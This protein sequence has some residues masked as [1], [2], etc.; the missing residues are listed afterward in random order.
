MVVKYGRT[1]LYLMEK[2]TGDSE[3]AKD[4]VQDAFIIVLE[5][6]RN[7]PLDDPTKLSAYLYNTAKN[8]YIGETRKEVRR[9]TF[10]DTELLEM[11]ASSNG[12]QYQTLVLERSRA[13]IDRLFDDLRN[14]RD[15]MILIHYYIDEIEKDIIC[16]NLGLSHR[17]FDRVI[18]RARSRFRDIVQEQ[19]DQIPL[20]VSA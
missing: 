13:A 20:E 4:V 6:L 16:E 5:K 1:L 7:E 19:L 10:F 15:R 17:H 3:R 2:R 12:E 9:E 18:S 8:V 11:I 14:D